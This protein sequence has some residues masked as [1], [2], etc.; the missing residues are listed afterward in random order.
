MT[1]YTTVEGKDSPT[2]ETMSAKGNYNSPK[3]R[4]TFTLSLDASTYAASLIARTVSSMIDSDKK[5][6]LV[7][8]GTR[9]IPA[10]TE[11]DVT[12]Q[13]TLSKGLTLSG[14][15]KNIFD[16]MPPFSEM[17]STNQYGSQG[18]AQT[19]NVRGRYFYFG[20]NY[21]FF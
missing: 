13:Y 20:A 4:N 2:D 11:I 10:Y 21:K 5:I 7:P 16:N 18:F 1:Y 15:I 3:Y 9:T 17:G 19:Y 6:P 8:V 12:G 14:G